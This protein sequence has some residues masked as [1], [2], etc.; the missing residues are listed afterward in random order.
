MS[1][2]CPSRR[3]TL[4][5]FAMGGAFLMLFA[6]SSIYA[7]RQREVSRSTSMD[8]NGHVVASVD[9][10]GTRRPAY[11]PSRVLVRFRGTPKFLA[12]SGAA[13][14]F[15]GD[16]HLF[17]VGN[18]AGVSVTETIRRYRAMPGVI[19]AEPDYVLQVI[20][21]PADPLW[22]QQWDMIK[23]AAPE[24]WDTQTSSNDV[25]VAVIDTGIDYTHPD[26]L[27]NL[28]VNPADNS[29]GYTCV[30]ACIAGGSDDF[31]HGTHVAGTI[32]AVDNNGIGIA[33]INWSVQLLSLKFL[34]SNGNGY[35][36]DAV[37][38]FD[39]ATALKQQ[40]FN[41]RVT[42][43]SWGGDAFSQS[44]KDAMSRAES[45]G[46]VHVCAAGNS[47][48]NTDTFPIYPAAYDNRGIISVL[49]S[50]ENDKG[51][52][53]SDFGLAGVDIAAPGVDVLSTVPTTGCALCDPSGY[54]LLSGTSMATPHVSGVLAALFHINP[55]LQ[56]N[57]ARDI[58]LDPASYDTL[59]DAR[60]QATSTGGRL[61]FSKA[62]ANPL[63]FAPV[64]N[65]FPSITMGPDMFVSAIPIMTRCAWPGC[66]LRGARRTF[67]FL[68]GP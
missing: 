53:F 13:H 27:A 30:N 59:T 5:R 10:A 18:P 19:Y 14:D 8:A 2:V 57:E 67:G 39:Q 25:V 9:V 44:L 61:N 66:N 68:A 55:S 56:A 52:G 62:I 40:G 48:Q 15:A 12:G 1:D 32:G 64:L 63:L 24:A 37:L 35:T 7:Q 47:G 49:A 54:R 3:W 23:I 33:G 45:N 65:N 34:D 38:A 17:V 46:I 21:T 36:S 26:L 11:H 60:A 4:A 16:R 51:V 42:S 58:I 20:N 31:G 43:N 22:N 50:D 28:W 29:H 6:G 41:I